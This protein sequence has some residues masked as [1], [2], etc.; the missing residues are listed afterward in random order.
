ML[1]DHRQQLC[2]TTEFHLPLDCCLLS[3]LASSQ[4]EYELTYF[5]IYLACKLFGAIS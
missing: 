4:F 5:Q 2:I 3:E 1:L